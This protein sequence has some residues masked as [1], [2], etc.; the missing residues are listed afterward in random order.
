MTID[1]AAVAERD[2]ERQRQRALAGRQS[3]ILAG[4]TGAPPTTSAKTALG[5]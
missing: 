1:D 2:R 5:Q 3:T 4:D